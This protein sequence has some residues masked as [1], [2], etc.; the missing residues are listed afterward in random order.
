MSTHSADPLFRVFTSNTNL[1]LV[2]KAEGNYI[3][4]EGKRFLDLTGGGTS[5]AILGWNNEEVNS[6]IK[7]QLVKYTHMDYKIWDDPNTLEL[8]KLVL[9][10]GLASLK[11]FYFAGNSGAEA[12]EAAMKMSRQAHLSKGQTQKKWFIS[13]KQSYHGSTADALAL[14]DRP[15]LEIFR[16]MLSPY[17]KHV[18]M[19]HFKKLA[20]VGESEEAYA[21]RCARELEETVVAIGPENVAGFVGETIMG[22]LVGDVPPV[23]NYWKK[24]KEVCNKYDVHLILDEVY[25]GTGTSGKYFCFE[26]DSIEPDFVFIGKTLAAG[27]GALSAVITTDSIYGAIANSPEARLQHTTT[28]QAHSLSVSAAIAVQGIVRTSGFVESVNE[29]G[30]IFREGF[31]KELQNNEHIVD[32]RGRGLRFSVEHSIPAHRQIKFGQ[33][34]ETLMRKKHSILVNAKWHRICFTPPITLTYSEID[35]SVSKISYELNRELPQFANHG[36]A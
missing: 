29:K 4:S 31:L 33:F 18:E 20:L 5:Y 1:P 26:Y 16:D 30:K 3:Y 2:E 13:R 32:I 10:T 36:L 24:I 12:C 23:G 14:G 35:E 17:R 11:K 27:Y 15:N 21:D 19:H 25:C 6:A 8:A 22:G 9:G 34:F 7:S 28:H